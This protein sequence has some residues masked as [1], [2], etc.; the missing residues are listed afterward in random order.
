[1][2][3]VFLAEALAMPI[4]AIIELVCSSIGDDGGSDMDIDELG[5]ML[6]REV[7]MAFLG[8]SP[9]NPLNQKTVTTADLGALA[10]RL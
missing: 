9:K 8:I 7:Y 6:R 2:P 4:A 1:M 5:L 10:R 3:S